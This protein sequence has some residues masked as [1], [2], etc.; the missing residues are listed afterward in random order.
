[1][2]AIKTITISALTVLAFVL[3]G[4]NRCNVG[5][6]SYCVLNATGYKFSELD[7]VVV[8][9]YSPDGTFTHLVNTAAI[10]REDAMGIHSWHSASNPNDTDGEAFNCV[11]L[12]PQQEL[13]FDRARYDIEVIVTSAARTY[14]FSKI[15]FAGP[16]KVKEQCV[17]NGKQQTVGCS[18]YI[19]SYDLNG[20][21]YSFSG[22]YSSLAFQK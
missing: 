13:D 3:Q 17:A 16:E 2:H 15:N 8:N 1:M 4:C 14:R 22:P 10:P 7:S 21:P 12:R 19:T 9:A 11:S 6:T 18:R 20:K 5:C